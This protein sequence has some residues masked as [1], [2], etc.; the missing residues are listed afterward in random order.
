MFQPVTADRHRRRWTGEGS[1]GCRHN[2]DPGGR[3]V[4]PEW[5]TVRFEGD[6]EFDS[7]RLILVHRSTYGE[8]RCRGDEHY[9]GERHRAHSEVGFARHWARAI[10]TSQCNS[11]WRRWS[12]LCC[13][14][15]GM[16]FRLAGT[17]FHPCRSFR[18]ARQPIT[19]HIILK[20]SRQRVADRLCILCSLGDGRT[21]PALKASR[22]EPVEALWDNQA[23]EPELRAGKYRSRAPVAEWDCGSVRPRSDA[24]DHEVHQARVVVTYFVHIDVVSGAGDRERAGEKKRRHA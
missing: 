18:D 5:D 14:C 20:T 23:R 13:R 22:M 9:A 7:L 2:F 6:S 10:A 3:Q 8:W 12:L 19:T 17:P 21:W 11:W 16:W 24:V 1:A 4:Q 15:V